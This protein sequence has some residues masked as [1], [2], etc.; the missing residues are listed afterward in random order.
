[1]LPLQAALASSSII[2]EEQMPAPEFPEIE[3]ALTSTALAGDA[4]GLYRIASDLMDNGVPFDTLLFDYLLAAERS[5]GKR[6]EQGDYLVAEEHAVT[7]AIETVI[8]L[9]V[10]MFD[11]P[12]DGPAVVVVTAEGDDHSLPARAASAHLVYLGYRTTFLGANIPGE[13]LR[14]FL[15]TEPPTLLVLS[16]AMSTH[17]LGAR[18]VIEAAHHAGVPVLAGGNGFG[19]NGEWADSVGADAW[20]GTLDGVAAAAEKWMKEPPSVLVSVP[21]LQQDLVDLLATRAATL[22]EAAAELAGETGAA[23]PSRLAAELGLLFDSVAGALFTKDDRVLVDMLRWQSAS[24]DAHGHDAA[25]VATAL[26]TALEASGA[27]AA[28]LLER[29]RRIASS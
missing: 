24:L 11:Q 19:P 29:A 13:D 26:Q 28:A 8:S 16:M 18:G 9:L 12:A 27:S 22:V 14:E 23:P 7:A 6:W 2:H 3:L 20:I 15:E 21:D 10:G 25:A 17:L 1:M 4:G 5:V